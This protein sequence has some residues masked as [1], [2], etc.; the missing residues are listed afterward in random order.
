MINEDDKAIVAD[1]RARAALITDNQLRE[2]HG[3]ACANCHGRGSNRTCRHNED[4]PGRNMDD[5]IA[6]QAALVPALCEIIERVTDEAWLSSRS[7]ERAASDNAA[8]IALLRVELAETIEQRDELAHTNQRLLE[9]HRRVYV[10]TRPMLDA[11]AHWCQAEDNTEE[12]GSASATLFDE[13]Q[14][15]NPP[16]EWEPYK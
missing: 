4:E 3:E 10:A 15:F 13:Y 7:A 9:S 1:A 12:G 8:T 5:E 16:R 11:V 2:L 14:T 6:E